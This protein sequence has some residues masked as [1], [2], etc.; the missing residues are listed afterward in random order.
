MERPGSYHAIEDDIALLQKESIA[1]VV[2]LTEHPLD[3]SAFRSSRIEVHHIPVPDFDA[4]TL[5]Q[6]RAVCTI[7]DAAASRKEASLVHC[8]AG[9]GRTGTLA[10]C[11]LAHHGRLDGRSAIRAAREVEP[12]YVQS[13]RQEEFVIAFAATFE[14]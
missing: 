6:T 12:G 8:L 7:V 3:P 13:P 10:A 5:E 9:L 1:H 4:P 2:S 14:K 11:Y